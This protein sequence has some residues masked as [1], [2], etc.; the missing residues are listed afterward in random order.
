MDEPDR[1]DDER[2]LAARQIEAAYRRVERREELVLDENAGV[3]ERVHQRRLAGIGVADERDRH[4]RDAGAL[5]AVQVA[6]TLDLTQASAQTDDALS[7][8]PAVDLELRLAGSACSDAA[9][10]AREMRPRAGE[11]R[12]HVLELRQLDL[13]LALEAARPS[14]EDVEDQLAAIEDL[15]VQLLGQVALLRRAQVLVDEDDTGLRGRDLLLH[16]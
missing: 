7:D 6:R 13:E 14:G 2:A 9:A 16:L 8:A 5:A 12:Q 11:A 10:E 15:D 4:V 1:I 3:R